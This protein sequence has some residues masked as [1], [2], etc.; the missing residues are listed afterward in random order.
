MDDDGAETLG[1]Q[2]HLP[3]VFS[4]RRRLRYSGFA[5]VDPCFIDVGG[6]AGVRCSDSFLSLLRF[7]FR[8]VRASQ[9]AV[10]IL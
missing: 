8:F 9:E 10:V 4:W 2:S 5:L 7:F 3:S 6:R 1:S